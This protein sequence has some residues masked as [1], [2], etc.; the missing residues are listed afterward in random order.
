MSE[1]KKG[2]LVEIKSTS[3][4]SVEWDIGRVIEIMQS[5][6]A[7]VYWVRAGARYSEEVHRLRVVDL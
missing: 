4:G 1:V 5:S 3:R 7:S 2:S 6:I